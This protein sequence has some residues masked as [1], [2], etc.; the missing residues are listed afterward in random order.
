MVAFA[1]LCLTPLFMGA[2]NGE[3]S[4]GVGKILSGQHELFLLNDFNFSDTKDKTFVTN[5]YFIASKRDVFFL[6]KGKDTSLN[7]TSLPVSKVKFQRENT[8]IPYVKFRWSS[9]DCNDGDYETAMQHVL[10]AVICTN[11]PKEEIVLEKRD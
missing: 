9:G 10:Y 1:F 8:E 7:M 11:K 2:T 6:W 3:E 5:Q 4:S